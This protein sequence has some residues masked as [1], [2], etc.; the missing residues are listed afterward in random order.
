LEKEKVDIFINNFLKTNLFLLIVIYIALVV[1]IPVV[2]KLAWMLFQS[3][4]SIG[5]IELDLRMMR[6]IIT[7]SLS[8][9][10]IDLVQIFLY[11]VVFLIIKNGIDI[12]NLIGIYTLN[13]MFLPT[14]GF[15]ILITKNSLFSL[16]GI[17]LMIVIT[18]IC[19]NS[20][21]YQFKWKKIIT[22]ALMF[23]MM[24]FSYI[25]VYQIFY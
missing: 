22:M 17:I 15:V 18:S 25:F 11:F 9:L 14:V 1:L 5:G 7:P 8:V 19:F 23:I 16:G 6:F 12:K 2:Y 21:K 20:L 13:K 24:A 4:L 3:R 10:V